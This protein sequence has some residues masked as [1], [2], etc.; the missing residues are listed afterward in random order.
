MNNKMKIR[1]MVLGWVFIFFGA[2]IFCRFFYLQVIT[3]ENLSNLGNRQH[4]DVEEINAER[5]YIY[6]CK[7]RE[8]AIS[9][10]VPSVYALTNQIKDKNT[11]ICKLSEMLN[12]SKKVISGK[13]NSKKTFVWIA[14]KVDTSTGK[15]IKSLKL[16]GVSMVM[17]NKRFYPKSGLCSHVLGFVGIDEEGLEGVEYY[18]ND[19]LGGKKGRLETEKDAK[20]R[21][22]I[23]DNSE[24]MAPKDGND[25][26]LTIDEAIQSIVEEELSKVYEDYSANGATAI[27]MN[28]ST[29][30]ILA[31]AN[32][33]AY[34]PNDFS[35]SPSYVLKNR[36]VTNP[37]EPGSV[38]KII[39]LA[40][41]LGDR[42]AS[43]KETIDCE[44]GE[45]MVYDHH[46]N[47][48]IKYNML[49]FQQVIENS[50]N[51]GTAKVGMRIGNNRMYEYAR[52]FGFGEKTNVQLAGESRGILSEPRKWSGISVCSISI[53]QEIG[54]TSLQISSAVSAVANKGK[55]MQ[56]TIVRAVKTKE[57]K[58]IKEFKPK[59]VR[60]VVNED[61]VKRM[62]K[63]LIGAVENGTGKDAA[64]DGYRVAGKTGTAQ[65][66]DIATKKYSKSKYIASFVG[67]VPA[68]NPKIVI[69]VSIDEPA[70]VYWG[71]SVAAP[72]FSKI[73][74]R[75][76]RYMEKNDYDFVKNYK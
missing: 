31:M 57:G 45:W 51:I 21:E 50:S 12:I 33:P 28:P 60:Q 6:D 14:R 20:G 70:K 3:Q 35:D 61:I 56:P 5:G 63:I 42:K 52:L 47:D 76:L 8:L 66:I 73:G 15:K 54:A 24:Y 59:E 55:L 29:G 75:V 13:L 37:F 10:S 7:S 62:V 36:A 74:K 53:G 58:L 41:A 39:T 69:F 40:A 38:F 71:G 64:I 27:V 68:D 48:H 2:A 11:T 25:V 32:R 16:P 65:K 19:Y 30:E 18:F 67:F 9:V 26:Y 4:A 17:E 44:N 23:T 46:I 1:I 72:V 22:I 34:N 43:E 49:T